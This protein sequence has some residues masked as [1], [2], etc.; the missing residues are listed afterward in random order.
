MT[1]PKKCF[2]YNPVFEAPGSS[3][4]NAPCRSGIAAERF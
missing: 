3:V 1:R 2:V 4:P